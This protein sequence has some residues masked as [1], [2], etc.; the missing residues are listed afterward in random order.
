MLK[1]ENTRYFRNYATERPGNLTQTWER[2]MQFSDFDQ[3]W[4]TDADCH[5]EDG[6]LT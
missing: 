5:S 3:I 2:K 1:H 6:L 4:Y